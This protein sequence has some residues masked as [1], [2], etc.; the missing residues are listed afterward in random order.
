[1]RTG[2]ISD[3]HSNSP[4]LDAVLTEFENSGVKKIFCAG[5]L[6]G[7]NAFPNKT[8]S[9]IQVNE[10]TAVKGN[11]DEAIT[12]E[13]PTN[14]KISAKRAIDWTRR[15]LC[16]DELSYLDSLPEVVRTEVDGLDIFLVHGSPNNPLNQYV[17]KNEIRSQTIDAWFSSKPDLLIL[18]HTHRQFYTNVAGVKIVNPG[19]VGQPRDG[20][21]EAAFAILDT[22]NCSIELRRTDY[23]V[24]KTAERTR[25]V[26]PRELG[27]RLVEGND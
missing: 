6:L 23:D 16:S 21:R 1:M 20:N 8:L 11:H 10:I 22:E 12:T 5:D 9:Q 13:T 14:F 25:A 15:Q 27:D 24:E 18:G 7:Y 3:V 2:L 19:S 26:L 4:A 17:Y